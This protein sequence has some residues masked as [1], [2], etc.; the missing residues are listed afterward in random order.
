MRDF[1]G[2]GQAEIPAEACEEE[3]VRY[4]YTETLTLGPQATDAGSILCWA[5]CLKPRSWMP[6]RVEKT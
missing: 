3:H 1:L 5:A 6:N 4:A 2:L